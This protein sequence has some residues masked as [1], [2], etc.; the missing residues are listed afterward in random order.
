MGGD[1][2]GHF[3]VIDPYHMDILRSISTIR[4]YH[5]SHIILG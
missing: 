1:I 5:S 3:S 2:S 4:I